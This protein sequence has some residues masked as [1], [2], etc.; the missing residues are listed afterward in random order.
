MH[1]VR[2]RPHRALGA[3]VAAAAL[4]LTAA[5]VNA[6]SAAAEEEHPSTQ[7]RTAAKDLKLPPAHAGFD[8]QIGGAYKPPAGVGVVTRDHTA[9]PAAG[10]YN[11]C[12]VNAYQTQPGA[13]NQWDSDLLLKDADGK[14]I[15]DGEWDGEALLDLRTAKK[16]ERIAAKVNGWID[17]CA[18]KG[19]QAVEPDNFD[20]YERSEKLLNTTQA[21]EYARLLTEHAHSK[22]LAVGQKN[23]SELAGAHTA[24]GFDFAVAEQCGQW[25][26]CESYTKEFGDHVVVIEYTKDGLA[27]ACDGWGDQLSIVRR[28][29]NVVPPSKAGY[30][31][32]TCDG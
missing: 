29:L 30:V 22:G 18:A 25:D 17:E 27:K 8:Y 14:V 1:A 5:Q 15:Y 19:F 26:E 9:E 10:L 28:D 21:Q 2:R 20:S 16:R 31:R 12:Y 4:L 7:D 23:A 24:N 11:I 13:A 6:S 32:E 3:A